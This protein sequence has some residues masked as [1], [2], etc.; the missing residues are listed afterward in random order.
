MLKNDFK[1]LELAGQLIHHGCVKKHEAD[2]LRGATITFER[3]AKSPE[4]V[5]L[6]CS[7]GLSLDGG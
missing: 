3:N 4:G 1:Q 7:C 2:R 5:A 6:A